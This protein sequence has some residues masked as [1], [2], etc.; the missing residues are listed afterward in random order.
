MN[1]LPLYIEKNSFQWNFKSFKRIWKES[2]E[3]SFNIY[4]LHAASE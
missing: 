2:E 4:N 3:Y 1:M